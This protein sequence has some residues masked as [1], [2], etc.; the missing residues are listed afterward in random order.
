MRI[1]QIAP[2][3]LRVPPRGYGGIEWV[4]AHLANGLEARG[5]EVTLFAARGSESRARIEATVGAPLGTGNVPSHEELS[6]ALAAYQ[7][8]GDFD[9]IHDHTVLGAAIGSVMPLPAPVFHTLHGPW[10]DPMRRYYGL[11]AGQLGLV[12]ISRAQQ[13]LNPDVPYAGMVHNGVALDSFP[14]RTDND[15]YLLFVGRVS[16]E[17]GPELAIQVAHEVG[18]PLKMVIK[19]HEPVEQEYW[20]QR[21]APLLTGDEEIFE[22]ADVHKKLEL[23]AGAVATLFP[24]Q[25]EEPFGLV[26]VESMACGTP[27]IARPWGAA[28]EVVADGETGFLRDDVGAMAEAV[29]LVDRIDPQSCRRRVQDHFSAESM[30]RGYEAIFEMALRG[31]PH[32]GR[33]TRSS[34]S[35]GSRGAQPSAPR[36]DR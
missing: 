35:T 18:L 12:A 29:S 6:H 27:V 28:K 19:R 25:W 23:Y 17:K 7:R 26:M 31:G 22:G 21:V 34:P 2:I 10:T 36:R 20:E 16:P 30:V 14:F 1:A 24:I 32:M 33:L 13:H 3:A 5:H 15:G 4:V 11:L 9:V 8:A